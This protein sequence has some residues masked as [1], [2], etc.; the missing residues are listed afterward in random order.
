[1]FQLAFPFLAKTVLQVAAVPY[2]M[3]SQD[4]EVLIVTSRRNS[5]WIIPKGWPQKGRSLAATA[6]QEAWEEAGVRGTIPSD[7]LGR[8]RASK[9]TNKGYDVAT[10]VVVFPLLV[11]RMA[12]AWPE[13]AF[14]DRA[15]HSFA[16][17]TDRLADRQLARLLVDSLQRDGEKLR[18]LS[19]NRHQSA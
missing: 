14:R 2:R 15:W 12:E 5:R 19:E 6:E 17:A 3:G 18:T 16:E 9:Q 4:V 11:E 7:A 1:M 10:D 13:Q 8:Y